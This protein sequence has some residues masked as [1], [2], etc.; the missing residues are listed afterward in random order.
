MIQRK[1]KNDTKKKKKTGE[2]LTKD[3]M[4]YKEKGNIK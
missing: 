3:D 4:T 1:M 2:I